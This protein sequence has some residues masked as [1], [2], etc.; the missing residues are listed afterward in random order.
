MGINIFEPVVAY[1]LTGVAVLE[2]KAWLKDTGVRS[3]T[4]LI[5]DGNLA[6]TLAT[7]LFETVACVPKPSKD[8]IEISLAA[9][10]DCPN[11]TRSPLILAFMDSSLSVTN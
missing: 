7:G 3:T 10:S 6:G 5:T 11:R 1:M 4:G 9:L 2:A 8:Q